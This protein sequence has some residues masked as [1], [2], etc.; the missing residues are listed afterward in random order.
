MNRRI[1][2]TIL[3]SLVVIS[4]PILTGASFDPEYPRIANY[5]LSWKLTEAD[6]EALA[7]WD[8]II[9][10]MEV[11]E[12]SP[13]ELALIKEKNPDIKILAYIA[14]QEIYSQ[15][16]NYR[17]DNLRRRFLAGIDESW[18]LRDSAGNKI[19][20]WSGTYMFNMSTDFHSY[21]AD[22]IEQ[23]IYG[24]GHFDGVFLDNLWGSVSFVNSGDIDIDND[25]A[26]ETAAEIDQTWREGMNETISQLRD[27]LP[28]SFIII[29]NGQIHFDYQS[30][31]NGMMLEG[32]PSAWENGGTWAGSM[33]SYI[34]LS[35]YNRLPQVA[36]INAHDNNSANYQKMRFGLGSTLLGDG[37]YSFDFDVTNHSQT[38]WY[39]EYEANL[40]QPISA[41]FNLLSSDRYSW[42]TG[43]WRRDFNNGIV[44]VNSSDKEQ[45][46]LFKNEEFEKLKGTQDLQVN[47]GT[48]INWVSLAPKDGLILYKRQTEIRGASYRNGYF[49]R[50]FDTKGDQPRNGFFAYQAAYPAGSRILQQDGLSLYAYEGAVVLGD[51]VK[52][53]AS[54]R[55]F[56]EFDGEIGIALAD[57]SGD[58]Q[59]EIITGAGPGGGPHV[60][61]FSQSGQVLGSFFAY[62]KNFRGGVS[63]AA[64]D[65]NGD[66]QAEII[67]GAGPGGGPHVRIFSQSGQVLGS[68]FAYDKNFRGG[69]NVG[70]GYIV[71]EESPR[72]FA[73][74]SSF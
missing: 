30:K 3:F 8:V 11:S 37:Y 36:V 10:D 47:D 34:K 41:P 14:S 33:Q 43:L 51:S 71:G 9:L 54:F 52:T 56:G 15:P 74:S 38:W 29:G 70:Y 24:S 26:K 20:H 5:F 25:G 2:S 6:A 31:L 57:I 1:L 58:G 40:G 21:L 65:L 73:F 27:F 55:P 45:R 44:L 63:V 60:R 66:G 48:I 72:I 67:T 22:F 19:S 42:Q 59:A 12:N 64:G 46:F 68:F 17:D 53:I 18:W 39:D 23:D 49:A 13:D 16:E 7:K 61:I 28:S 69:V 4:V 32:F 50:I 62:D 35:G